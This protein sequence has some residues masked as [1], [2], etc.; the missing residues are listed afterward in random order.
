MLNWIYQTIIKPIL[1]FPH[2][3]VNIRAK[4]GPRKT[5][6]SAETDQASSDKY[7]PCV[8]VMVMTPGVMPVNIEFDISFNIVSHKTRTSVTRI[9]N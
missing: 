8:F 4:K 9:R 1:I 3:V 7:K 5:L 2:L 6:E